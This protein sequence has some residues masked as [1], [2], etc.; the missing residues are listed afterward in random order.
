MGQTISKNFIL[1]TKVLRDM[2]S[3]PSEKV[4]VKRYKKFRDSGKKTIFTDEQILHIR[5]LFEIQGLR[6]I[7][8]ATRFSLHYQDVK[9]VTDCRTKAGLIPKKEN[10]N[11]VEF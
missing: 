7:D 10:L 3:Q 1:K 4:E 8:I 9:R 6:T 2:V 5:A 11:P